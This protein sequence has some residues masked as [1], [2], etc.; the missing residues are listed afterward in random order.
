MNVVVTRNPDMASRHVLG[1][2]GSQLAAKHDSV[3][4]LPTGS[5]PLKLYGLIAEAVGLGKMSFSNAAT[6]NLDEYLGIEKDS[7]QS[8]NRFMWDNLFGK[9]DIRK[10]NVAI[11][12]PNPEDPDRFCSEYESRIR[13]SG[14]DIAII[15]IG[16][17]GHIGFNEPGTSFSSV[18]HVASL[19]K[20]TVDA[21]S[22]FFD[23]G[24]DVPKRAITAG[25]DTIMA[26][27]K[28]ILLAFGKNKASAVKQAIEGGV[29]EKTP[30]SV[31]QNHK[32]VTFVMDTDAASML[33]S[34]DKQPPSIGK[35]SMYSEFNL[36]A[37]KKILFF[38]PHP[39]DA[40]IS[41][42]GIISAL[43]EGND[44]SQI[45]MTSGFHGITGD[46]KVERIRKREDETRNEAKT[47]GIESIFMNC[48]FY[49]GDGGIVISDLI[50]TRELVEKIKPDIIFVPQKSDPH[51]THILARK[52]VLLSIP[53]GIE[54][55][56]Y[57]TPWGLFGHSEFNACFEL[58]EAR[59]DNKLKAIRMHSSQLERTRFDTAAKNIG[60][61]R[62]IILTEQILDFGVSSIETQPY[63][64]LF[65][66]TKS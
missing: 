52:T 30:A 61:T 35:V 43:A 28:I 37:G 19:T 44:V 8:Y 29:T 58:S 48:E 64:E 38:S 63:L 57:E 40:A 17:N 34:H 31:L 11:P 10:E 60:E 41:A 51:P 66:I 16:E 3:F 20:S 65:N 62:R 32:D 13:H 26:A 12:E 27:D 24:K 23:S 36:P 22:R 56:E 55:W 46:R 1:I 45:I 47:L 25:L 54:I 21:N 15:G 39:D 42:G 6:F 5:T 33:E 2:I 4:L 59:M 9:I 53:K 7:P 14:I 18:T 50:R 49:D